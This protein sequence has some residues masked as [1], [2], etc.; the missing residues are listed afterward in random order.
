MS[1]AEFRCLSRLFQICLKFKLK[2]VIK[3][4]FPESNLLKLTIL[5]FHE[6]YLTGFSYGLSRLHRKHKFPLHHLCVHSKDLQRLFCFHCFAHW[7]LNTIA[8]RLNAQSLP[9]QTGPVPG[10]IPLCILGTHRATV[11]FSFLNQEFMKPEQS[12]VRQVHKHSLI[13]NKTFW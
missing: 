6:R 12:K 7:Q 4:T 8:T 2:T 5:C 10:K 9:Q 3:L 1:T 13:I 11:I